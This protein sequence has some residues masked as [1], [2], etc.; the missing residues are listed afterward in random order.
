MKY[1]KLH[2]T[3][4]AQE[5]YTPR[6]DA[7][8]ILQFIP[9]EWT[10]YE[11]CWGDGDMADA[12]RDMEY[13][14]VGG[15]DVDFFSNTITNYDCIITNP[16]WRNHKDFIQHAFTLGKPFAF[17]LRL[18]HIGGVRAYDLFKDKKIQIIIPKKRINFI[19]Q[20]MRKGIKATGSPFHSIW[21]TYGLGL[22][23]DI[24]WVE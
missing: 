18:E 1:P 24:Q 4:L 13:Q 23:S 19:T 2:T 21:L 17:L 22:E 9:K 3:D 16:P 8:K 20:K 15:K 10:I 11:C 7:V 5:L 12:F 14:V 6:Q